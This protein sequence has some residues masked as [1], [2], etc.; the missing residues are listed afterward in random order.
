M[1]FALAVQ[2]LERIVKRQPLGDS[3]REP[4]FFFQLFVNLEILPV[5]R[6]V[7]GGSHTMLGQVG[8]GKLQSFAA[9][10]VGRLRDH[11]QHGFLRCLPE[12][13]GGLAVLVAINVSALGIAAG[14][15]NAAE[16]QSSRIGYGDVA[17]DSHE[18]YGM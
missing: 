2:L 12:N 8:K 7:L 15:R 1:R 17:V 5:R 18:K 3:S 16:L 6:I 11:A 10:L 9:E 13:A 14:Q 4:A